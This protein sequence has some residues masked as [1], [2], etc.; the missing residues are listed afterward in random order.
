[1]KTPAKKKGDSSS[2]S[3]KGSS[4]SSGR[5]AAAAASST[6]AAASATV[7]GS[8]S[9]LPPQKKLKI[10]FKTSGGGRTS[11]SPPPGTA[12]SHSS[13]SSASSSSKGAAGAPASSTRDKDPAPPRSA[14]RG[15]S[16]AAAAKAH[17]AALV[18]TG[19]LKCEHCFAP[20]DGTYGSGRFCN[21]ACRSRFNGGEN[22]GASGAAGGRVLENVLNA[23]AGDGSGGGISTGR[24]DGGPLVSEDGV[25]GP[26]GYA[27]V[28]KRAAR[29]AKQRF[30]QRGHP[31]PVASAGFRVVD[32]GSLQPDVPGALG[33]SLCTKDMLFPLGYKSLF[34]YKHTNVVGRPRG[35]VAEY[36]SSVRSHPTAPPVFAVVLAS[37]GFVA[38]SATAP[39][40]AWKPIVRPAGGGK[41]GAGAGLLSPGVRLTERRLVRCQAVL[42]W[43]THRPWA[44]YFWN[45]VDERAHPNYRAIVRKPTCLK[46]VQ[47]R[48]S[49]KFYVS[50][51]EFMADLRLVFANYMVSVRV[52]QNALVEFTVHLLLRTWCRLYLL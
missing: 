28:R 1:M 43:L 52:V 31:L 12:P 20:H 7:S 49:S 4:S 29:A 17:L 23:A 26:A 40:A 5:G 50:E 48:L 45:P 33:V 27:L 51:F 18:S 36:L 42:N 35:V 16:S 15:S 19:G 14:G 32:W 9:D 38:S 46:F 44:H 34:W 30:K 21:S 41:G 8:P 22:V 39:A 24:R 6:N 37:N 25:V 47:E 13:S 11:T 2:S 3:S 10:V